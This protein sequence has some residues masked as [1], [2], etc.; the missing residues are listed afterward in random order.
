MWNCSSSVVYVLDLAYHAV[1]LSL[2]KRAVEGLNI[3]RLREEAKKF[4]LR[5]Y[6]RTN[7]ADVAKHANQLN[8]LVL[9]I[10]Y[11]RAIINPRFGTQVDR[12]ATRS[13]ETTLFTGDP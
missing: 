8:V 7:L 4:R 9:A 2:A 11:N 3:L 12:M 1:R 10:H 13:A 5:D 6:T